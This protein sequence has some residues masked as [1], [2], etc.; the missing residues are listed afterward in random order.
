MSDA[1]QLPASGRF[2]ASKSKHGKAPKDHDDQRECIDCG[3]V[4]S[5]YNPADQCYVHAPR[6]RRRLRGQKVDT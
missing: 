2:T 6:V 3:T 4:L 5:R 1:V